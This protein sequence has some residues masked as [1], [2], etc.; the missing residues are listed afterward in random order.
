MTSNPTIAIRTATA[1]DIPALLALERQLPTSAHWSESHYASFFLPESSCR[2][3]LV[4][5]SN[6]S[7]EI[8]GFLVA[9][10]IPPEWELENIAIT[11]ASQRTGLGNQLFSALLRE[12][13]HSNSDAVFLEVRESNVA[14]R[15]FYEKAGFHEMGR[16]K[17]YY[18]N[19]QEDAIVY[20]FKLR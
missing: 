2:L 1:A 12:A 9:H 17:S 19:P 8:L 16:R 14:A 5:E 10:H 3:L 18:T 20:R 4:A 15:G 6:R 13:T 11:Q 7:A